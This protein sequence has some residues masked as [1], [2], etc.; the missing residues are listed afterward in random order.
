MG[1][2]K[3]DFKKKKKTL[4][5]DRVWI[6][7]FSTHL[8]KPYPIYVCVYIKLFYYISLIYIGIIRMSFEEFENIGI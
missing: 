1:C 5:L 7:S 3:L 4:G 8:T 2:V 6:D